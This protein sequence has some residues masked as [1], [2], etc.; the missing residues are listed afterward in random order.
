M[1]QSGRD[2]RRCPVAPSGEFEL[3]VGGVNQIVVSIQNV[4]FVQALFQ[5]VGI[6]YQ[7]SR[8]GDPVRAWSNRFGMQMIRDS[9]RY[10]R[11]AFARRVV[12]VVSVRVDGLL[13][14]RREADTLQ[15]VVLCFRV[16]CNHRINPGPDF[17]DIVPPICLAN[18]RSLL[19]DSKFAVPDIL[20]RVVCLL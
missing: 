1:L 19:P 9:R 8:M 4:R 5:P 3:R 6:S 20:Q 15:R 14:E 16:A 18:D 12:S 10:G 11:F 13:T 17:L 2:V 7:V